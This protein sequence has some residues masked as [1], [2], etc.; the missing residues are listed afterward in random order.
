M[1]SNWERE[2]LSFLLQPVRTRCMDCET[3][4][5]LFTGQISWNECR[6]FGNASDEASSLLAS[7]TRGLDISSNSFMHVLLSLCQHRIWL[8]KIRPTKTRSWKVLPPHR[9]LLQRSYQVHALAAFLGLLDYVASIPR[10]NQKRLSRFL[11]P[12]DA[13]LLHGWLRIG[14]RFTWK[15]GC[16]LPVENILAVRQTHRLESNAGCW[17]DLCSTKK[18][19]RDVRC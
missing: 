10:F 18:V 19:G 12:R 6:S 8:W 15:S 3:N 4:P 13:P 14:C 2:Y 17:Q 16:S 9:L 11:V 5:F 1:R 7:S